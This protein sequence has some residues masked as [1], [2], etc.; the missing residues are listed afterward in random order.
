MNIVL[1]YLCQH[2]VSLHGYIPYPSTCLSRALGISLYKTR[3]ELKLLKQQ[4]LVI[5]DHYCAVAEDGNYI[6]NGYTIT[7]AAESTP[8][9]QKAYAEEL[10]CL[11]LLSDIEFA[12][13]ITETDALTESKKRKENHNE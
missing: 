11:R 12:K 9:Y 13:G 4:G 7:K 3:K 2:C 8:E 5:S 6:V 1:F 10:A